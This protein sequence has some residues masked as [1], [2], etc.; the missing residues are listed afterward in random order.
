M[1][2]TVLV[3]NLSASITEST[4]ED[5]FTS[6]GNVIRAHIDFDAST[7]ASK[8]RGCVEMHTA[9]EVQD[10]ILHFHGQV[11]HGKALIVRDDKPFVPTAPAKSRRK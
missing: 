11:K 10:C 1:S 5:M 3:S 6:V 2:H 8:G 4:L 7:G 9:E